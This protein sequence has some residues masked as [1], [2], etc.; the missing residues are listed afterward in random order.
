[1][2]W[3]LE[4][5]LD[6]TLQAKFAGLNSPP[7]IQAFLDETPYST[8]DFNRCP[9]RVLQDG[10]ANCMDGALLAAAALRRLGW[11]ALIVDLLPEPGSDDDHIL[12]I[13]TRNGCFGAVAKSNFSCL[14]SREPVYRSLRELVMSYFDGYY[15]LQGQKTLRGYTR[16]VRLS[17]FD[18]L[19]WEVSDAGI[20]A[21]ERHLYT[22][23]P[24]YILSPE[25]AAGLAPM[26][27]LSYRS[28]LLGSNPDGLFKP[29]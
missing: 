8:A 9:L 2:T 11:P 10:V 7:S 13:Y 18:H 17:A 12:A 20:E 22:L 15:N 4:S 29:D 16:P 3:T 14:R 28:G 27:P 24:I 23:R 21:I 26:D 5:T 6:D 19:N 25:M 1:M